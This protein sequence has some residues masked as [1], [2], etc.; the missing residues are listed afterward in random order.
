M[1]IQR[2]RNP[3]AMARTTLITMPAMAPGERADEGPEVPGLANGRGVE[4][5]AAAIGQQVVARN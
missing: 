5:A 3:K 2:M 4:V 1:I